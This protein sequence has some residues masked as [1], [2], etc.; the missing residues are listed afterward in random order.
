MMA[1]RQPKMSWRKSSTSDRGLYVCALR[2][3]D[4]Y[5]DDRSFLSFIVNDLATEPAVLEERDGR[6]T[7]MYQRPGASSLEFVRAFKVPSRISIEESARKK[8]PRGCELAVGWVIDSPIMFTVGWDATH[9]EI[10]PI[11]GLGPALWS[12]M[13]DYLVRLR[14]A[15]K[16]EQA[17]A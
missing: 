17:V 10:L 12:P 13:H 6:L 8:F 14:E 1:Q 9:S 5:A 15:V 7:L 11:G 2:P 16:N 4:T 3:R